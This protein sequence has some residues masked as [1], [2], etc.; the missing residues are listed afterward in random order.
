MIPS[1]SII[2]FFLEEFER[3]PNPSLV[4]DDEFLDAIIFHKINLFAFPKFNKLYT[5]FLESVL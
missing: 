1:Q 3:E 4:L 2:L 5:E